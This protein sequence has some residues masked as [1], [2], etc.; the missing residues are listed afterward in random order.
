MGPL[1]F[2]VS[3]GALPSASASPRTTNALRGGQVGQCFG[4]R[5]G[6]LSDK[7][8]VRWRSRRRFD[9]YLEWL[10]AAI[11]SRGSND[12]QPWDNSG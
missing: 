3:H 5:G 4:V 8:K 7:D 6:L 12:G 2:C 1:D 10:S 11:R 9:R